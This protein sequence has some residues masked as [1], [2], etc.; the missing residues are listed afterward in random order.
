VSQ[1]ERE[2]LEVS[3][4]NIHELVAQVEQL[5]KELGESVDMEM[6]AVGRAEQAEKE[7]DEARETKRHLHRRTQEAES[8]AASVNGQTI[9]RLDDELAAVKVE[10]HA[11]RNENAFMKSER[12]RLQS[13]LRMAEKKRDEWK[14]RWE[15]RTALKLGF[16]TEN[17]VLTE[18]G[19]AHFRKQTEGTGMVLLSKEEAEQIIRFLEGYC[20]SAD[21]DP[22]ADD[23]EEIS[24][25]D[26]WVLSA[27]DSI[28]SA[29][30]AALSEQTRGAE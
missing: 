5:T 27:L 26:A 25:Q 8:V 4:A 28:R 13:R 18:A 9:Q 23:G 14:E 24:V 10:R 29:T 3:Q 2:A 17:N 22:R 1:P 6:E 21:P 16:V 20:E 11:F 19:W 7:R 30:S 12:K 15:S